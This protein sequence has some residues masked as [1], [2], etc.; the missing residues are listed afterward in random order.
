M[1]SEK[2]ERNVL[3]LSF[4]AGVVF[5]IA[6]IIYAIYSRSQSVLMD[7]IYDATELIFIALTLFMTPLFRKPISE[8]YPYGF[9]Q[10]ESIYI[11][12]KSFMML[13][14]SFGMGI[15]IIQSIISG[16]HLVNEMRV[17]GFQ[18]ILGIIS[19]FIYLIMKKWNK[20]TYSPTVDAEVIGWRIDWCYSLGLAIAFFLSSFISNTPL[21]ALAPYVD[22]TI[23]IIVMLLMIPDI[24]KM[25][26]DSLKDVFLF[27]P[28][29]EL[30]QTIKEQCGEE[31]NKNG[32]TIKFV[33]IIRTGRHT[34]VSLYYDT[35]K[36]LID[37]NKLKELTSICNDI[38]KRLAEICTVELILAPQKKTKEIPLKE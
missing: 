37:V 16:G 36:E 23:A 11:I 1:N 38:V 14:V 15:D 6:E 17:S 13:S 12:I 19:F 18:L 27:S 26:K 20:K 28:N 2:T 30:Y 10:V 22:S 8:K 29:K 3:L 35:C 24:F 33:D 25:L 5:A 21:K 7:G 34:W 4:F 32:L 9:Y 31:L